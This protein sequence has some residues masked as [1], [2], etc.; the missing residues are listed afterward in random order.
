MTTKTTTIIMHL[1]INLF[2]TVAYY[3]Y[4]TTITTAATIVVIAVV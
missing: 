4:F 3:C 2:F 1:P